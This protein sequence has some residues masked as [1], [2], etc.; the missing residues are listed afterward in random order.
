[1]ANG[2]GERLQVSITKPGERQDGNIA[3]TTKFNE[4][5]KE[6]TKSLP[7]RAWNKEEK[8]WLVPETEVDLVVE[9]YGQH[10]VLVIVS[11]IDYGL[12]SPPPSQLSYLQHYLA[13]ILY[14]AFSPDVAVDR[15]VVIWHVSGA[16]RMPRPRQWRESGSVTL[17][18]A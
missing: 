16:P 2:A 12:V 3:L 14:C 1:M 4:N 10:S 9:H 13:R 8:V 11:G 18:T 7:H 6:I 5:L 17:F 15:K